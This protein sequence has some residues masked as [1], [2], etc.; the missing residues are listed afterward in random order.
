MG[1]RRSEIRRVLSSLT[2]RYVAKFL[3][4]LTGMVM[5]IAALLY[6]IYS[7]RYFRDLSASIVDEQETLVLIYRGQGLAGIKQYIEDQR[8]ANLLDRFHYMILDPDGERIGGD[9]PRSTHYK[10]FD[11][12][13]LDLELG[14]LKWGESVDVDFLAR[15][16]D[17]GDGYRALVARN[18]EAV[19]F[20]GRL[21]F[22]TL[23]RAMLAT[24]LLGLVAGYFVAKRSMDRVEWL[25]REMSRII[26][27]DPSQRLAASL[28]AGHVGDLARIMNS[29]LEQTEELMQGMRS[30]S[31]NIAHDLRT[32]LGRLRNQLIRLRDTLPAE[33][34]PEVENLVADCDSLLQSFSAVLRIS[35][36][37]SGNRYTGKREVDLARLLRDVVELYEPLAQEKQIEVTFTGP[38]FP[39]NTRGDA[40]LLF[41]LFANVLDNAIKYTPEQG[42]IAVRLSSRHDGEHSHRISI[43]DS[44]PGIS[45][46]H[47][48]NVFRRFYRVDP[49]RSA[50]PGHG[51]G[52]SMAQAIAHYHRGH[53]DLEDNH[54]GLRV[55]ISLP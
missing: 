47:W 42:T 52:L 43:A 33:R 4:A 55:V 18:Y 21:V 16:I 38:P 5:L 10:V 24:I 39:A 50:Q 15:V 45:S 22:S 44:G 19:V 6:G 46:E 26:R 53:V 17:L 40:D 41:Q 54:P 3:L 11:D 37:E 9:L 30:I 36:L 51:L 48:G 27:G 14:L 8:D 31:D 34:R 25:G 49:S 29:M 35:T 32:P 7:Y 23:V 2:F 13:W 20:S 1:G 12:G 28:E